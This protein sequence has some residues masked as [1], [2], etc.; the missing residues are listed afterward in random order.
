MRGGLIQLGIGLT[1]GLAVA[2]AVAPQ[3]GEALFDEH[4]HDPAV[5]ALIGVVLIVTGAVASIVPGRRALTVSP[6][7]ALRSE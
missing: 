5:Y 7:T 1:L 3:F 4:P 6:M 2:A